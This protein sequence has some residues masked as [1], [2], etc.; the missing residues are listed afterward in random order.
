[1]KALITGASSGIGRDIARELSKTGCELILVARRESRLEELKAELPTNVEIICAD[2]SDAEACQTLHSKVKDKNIDM[3]INNAGV[4]VFGDF[5]KTDLNDELKLIDT[6]I[7][8]THILTKL[9]LMDF[10]ER[11]YG[12]ILNVSSASAFAPGPR[13]AA[14]YASKAYILRLSQAIHEELR[15][16]G[17]NVRISTLC[18]G[19]V[20]TEFDIKAG[21]VF[22][23]MYSS[24][25][26]IA[27]AAVE[28]IQK[29]KLII[30]PE[31]LMKFAKFATRILSDKMILRISYHIQRP[32]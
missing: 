15:R 26:R 23:V 8:G 1:M 25:E 30:I 31:K 9:F 20:L 18:C 19:P 12:F 27:K 11:N 4:G 7:R 3:L 29:A 22:N 16:C 21:N 10:I 2:I 17:S 6:N 32:S 14:Y 5:D 28:G 13:M 24:S